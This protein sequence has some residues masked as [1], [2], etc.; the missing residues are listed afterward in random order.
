MRCNQHSPEILLLQVGK[1]R[2]H[3]RF[4]FGERLAAL[5]LVSLGIGPAF[6]AVA[7]PPLDDFGPREP[8]PLTE[9]EFAKTRFDDYF[10]AGTGKDR[11]CGF[12][13]A[14]EIARIRAIEFFVP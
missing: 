6:H 4:N 1:E 3:S 9:I 8:F 5:G 11:L 7:R 13:R 2:S 14:S 12:D 10:Y